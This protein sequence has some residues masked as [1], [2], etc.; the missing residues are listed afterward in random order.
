MQKK[1]KFGRREWITTTGTA[2]VGLS[3]VPGTTMAKSNSGLNTTETENGL[4]ITKPNGDGITKGHVAR[5]RNE[6]LSSSKK[7]GEKIHVIDLEKRFG[8]QNRQDTVAYYVE[9]EGKAATERFW[10]APFGPGESGAI[11]VVERAKTEV[12]GVNAASVGGNSTDPGHGWDE[13]GDYSDHTYVNGEDLDGD[14]YVNGRIDMNMNVYRGGDYDPD[15]DNVIEYA[16][17]LSGYVWPGRYLDDYDSSV[18]DGRGYNKSTTLEQ[19]WLVGA[20][21]TEDV[22]LVN[23]SPNRNESGGFD[24]GSFTVGVEPNGP[25]GEVT[26]ETSDIEVDSI[27]NQSDPGKTVQT[28]YGFGGS[29]PSN[30]GGGE[31]VRVSNAGGFEVD[32]SSTQFITR[33]E[34]ESEFRYYA[35]TP[36]DL[37]ANTVTDF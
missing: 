35:D 5:A 3:A 36:S 9:W 27:E 15:D 2:L 1:R 23:F 7:E 26:V 17:G 18:D 24:L 10:S 30:L 31:T 20:T 21:S 33:G 19:D 16:C 25:Y 37:L 32:T 12:T 29:H 11:E 22:E 14:S 4:L 28:E 13:I 34:I 6:I 8:E